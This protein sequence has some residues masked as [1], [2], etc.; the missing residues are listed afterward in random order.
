MKSIKISTG[1]NVNKCLQ[2]FTLSEVLITLAIIGVLAAILVPSV[3]N[4][5]NAHEYRTAAKKAISV[6]NQALELE[7]SLEGLTA[8]D[9]TSAEE[10]VQKLFKKRMNNIVPS[11][12]EFT[13]ADCHNDSPDSIFTTSDGMIFCVSNF[14]SDNS[15]AP[16]SKCNY[17]NTVP[18]VKN[19]GANIWIDVNGAR[20]PNKV[21][22]DAS[23]PRDVYQ[24]QIY[25][26]RVIPYGKAT[27]SVL[28][29]D[30]GSLSKKNTNNNE[31]DSED[32]QNTPNEPEQNEED[33]N[34]NNNNM[35]NCDDSSDEYCMYDPDN[36]PSYKD[37]LDWM[38]GMMKDNH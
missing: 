7:Y 19:E 3:V 13:V 37:Y 27:Q 17:N 23:N 38:W 36:W 8:K 28:Y 4:K 34:N 31:S 15:D 10:I 25:S 24:A 6:L 2:A 29:N 14:Q 33:D 26:Q 5:T 22:V 11:L 1:F 32:N 21:T 18:C 35:P 9:F 16:N 30:E 12:E 20:K